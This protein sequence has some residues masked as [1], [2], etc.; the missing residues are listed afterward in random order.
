MAHAKTA[1]ML[2]E[3][4]RLRA[5]VDELHAIFAEELAEGADICLV[6]RPGYRADVNTMINGDHV[7]R[8]TLVQATELI[9]DYQGHEKLVI[10]IDSIDAPS[11]AFEVGRAVEA[12]KQ[13]MAQGVIFARDLLDIEVYTNFYRLDLKTGEW[14]N[15]LTDDNSHT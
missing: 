3:S 13:K 4:S 15:V 9:R 5:S 7:Q 2:F 1:F 12:R 14:T 10:F 6:E 11:I 8:L